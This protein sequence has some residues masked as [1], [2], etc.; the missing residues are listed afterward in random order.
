MRVAYCGVYVA[1]HAYVTD[2]AYVTD[3]AYAYGTQRVYV[4]HRL[5]APPGSTGPGRAPPTSP[6]WRPPP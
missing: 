6:D 3:H 5:N 2:R 1:Y 4:T